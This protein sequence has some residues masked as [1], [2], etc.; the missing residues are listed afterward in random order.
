MSRRWGYH[1]TPCFPLRITHSISHL[2]QRQR[3]GRNRAD[4]SRN[5]DA[6]QSAGPACQLSSSKGQI[7]FPV[8][9]I[10]S[11]SARQLVTLLRVR[12]PGRTESKGCLSSVYVRWLILHACNTLIINVDKLWKSHSIRITGIL[13][14]EIKWSCFIARSLCPCCFFCA[15]MK[16]TEIKSWLLGRCLWTHARGLLAMLLQ[17]VRLLSSPLLVSTSP[18]SLQA[19]SS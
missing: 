8:V 17:Q 9:H 19:L 5:T 11:S 1:T 12:M 18:S 7:R 16:S 13:P 2:G 3:L 4:F 15:V 6:S 14:S 10:T